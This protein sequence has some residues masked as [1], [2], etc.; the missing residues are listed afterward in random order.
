MRVKDE[1]DWIQ[2]SV[3]SIKKIAD[4]I[5]I[6]DNG[7]TDGTYELLQEISQ[8]EKGLI[9][10]WREPDLQYCDLSN[11][12]LSNT[13][14]RWILKWDGDFIAHTSGEYDITKLRDR[15]F[16][17]NDKRYYVIYL[18]LV[19]LAGDLSHQDPERMAHVEEY[20]YTYCNTARYVHPGRFEAVKFPKYHRVLFWYDPYIFHV[21]VKPA[22]RMLLR[23][24]W[25]D[26]MELKDYTRYP[27]LEDYVSE[28]IEEEFGTTS[29]EK[30][31]DILM[32]NTFSNYVRFNSEIFGPYPDLL[33][34]YVDNPKY[35]L[36]YE[37]NR[38]AGRIES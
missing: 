29:W 17:L 2:A 19:N 5:V 38:I 27:T 11:F 1:K 34:P 23:Y 35:K 7:S 6:V 32:Q 36:I 33:K 13:T 16:S 22:R 26:W 37:K 10:L 9:K 18:S 20:V 24:F 12:V 14:L 28:K 31:Q 8:N 25:E 4:E 21:N 3:R 30:A 15:I